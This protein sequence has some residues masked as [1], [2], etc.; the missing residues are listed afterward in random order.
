M[1]HVLSTHLFNHQW[2]PDALTVEKGFSP[3]T[4]KL[5]ESRGHKVELSTSVAR[6]EAIVIDQ[7]WL[8]GGADSRGYGKVEGY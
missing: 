2:Q 6:V 5:L 4:L 7:G 1:N 3:D 8:Q